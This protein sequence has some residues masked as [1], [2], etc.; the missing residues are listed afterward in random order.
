M[1]ALHGSGQGL[2]TDIVGTAVTAEGDE[3]VGVID[4]PALLQRIVCGLNAGQGCPG[5]CKCIVDITVLIRGI[6]IHERGYFQA[7]GCISDH[8]MIL[9]LQCT[10]DGAD[11]DTGTAAGTE[12]MTGSQTFRLIHNLFE[13]KCH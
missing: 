9:R 1:P 3:L 13:I 8:C 2:D 11:G 12:T 7:S 10:K 5:A 6:G 4:A